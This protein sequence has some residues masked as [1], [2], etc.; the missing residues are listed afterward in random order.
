MTAKTLRPLESPDLIR[1]I[2]VPSRGPACCNDVLTGVENDGGQRLNGDLSA[3]AL[4]T[5]ARRAFRP[6]KMSGSSDAD[7]FANI[8][9]T[10][11][12][13][14]LPLTTTHLFY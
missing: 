3:V 12:S 6:S 13:L 10:F 4:Q 8:V 7:R 2:V 14:A 9:V 1:P 11:G 5:P